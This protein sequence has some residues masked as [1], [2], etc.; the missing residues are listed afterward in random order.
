MVARTL[1]SAYNSSPCDS[2]S[3]SRQ[4]RITGSCI[5]NL[6]PSVIWAATWADTLS[7]HV[8]MLHLAVPTYP[9]S[10]KGSIRPSVPA[11]NDWLC[12]ISLF[13]ISLI[14][15]YKLAN[16][17][18]SSLNCQVNTDQTSDSPTC[19]SYWLLGHVCWQFPY[20]HNRLYKYEHV[21]YRSARLTE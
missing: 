10:C 5:Q 14:Q 9:P 16:V 8:W 21:C 15:L 12:Y 4:H 7:S 17:T 11:E 1:L 2:C 6:I 19:G 20:F 3:S 13:C 18:P